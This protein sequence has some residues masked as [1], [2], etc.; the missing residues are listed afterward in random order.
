MMNTFKALDVEYLR[1]SRTIET[2]LVTNKNLSEIFFVYNYEGVSYRVFKTH[3]DLIHFFQDHTD[4]SIHF[5][6]ED[7]LDDFLSEVKLAA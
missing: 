7:E 5:S 6:T 4:N 2:I 1:S 3:L